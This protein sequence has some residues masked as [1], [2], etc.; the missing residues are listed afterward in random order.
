MGL[1]A[2]KLSLKLI[3]IYY[4]ELAS[5]NPLHKCSEFLIGNTTFP[6]GTFAYELG[7][8]DQDGYPFVYSTKKN[9]TFGPGSSYFNLGA[10]NGTNLE[11]DLYVAE[12]RNTN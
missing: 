1:T 10:V 8:E 2:P 7:G 9:T 3:I 6:L 5:C 4:W 11:M 12:V